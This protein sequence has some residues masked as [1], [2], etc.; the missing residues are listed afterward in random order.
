MFW[1]I[2]LL[3]SSALVLARFSPESVQT[4]CSLSPNPSGGD[5][6]SAILEAFDRCSQDSIIVFENGTYHIEQVMN[7]TGLRNVKI[8]MHGTL[9][10]SAFPN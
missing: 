6:S 5:D 2:S 4:G 1:F 7:T 10:V 8:D 9:L 3:I